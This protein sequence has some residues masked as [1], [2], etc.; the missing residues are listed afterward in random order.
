MIKCSDYAFEI[1][2]KVN[3]TIVC[4]FVGAFLIIE[5]ADHIDPDSKVHGANVGP[6]WVLLSPGGPHVGP[7]NLANWGRIDFL[8][9]KSNKM[10]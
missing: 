2:A 9:C 5:H 7:M 1:A 6:T 4:R 3:K 8:I 10:H